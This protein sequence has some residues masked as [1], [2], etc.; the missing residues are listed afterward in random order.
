MPVR[1][2]VISIDVFIIG[3]DKRSVSFIRLSF[4]N[5]IKQISSMFIH[6]VSGLTF[7]HQCQGHRIRS[8][9][10]SWQSPIGRKL[11]DG[12]K[13][14]RRKTGRANSD[15]F[16]DITFLLLELFFNLN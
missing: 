10:E 7:H 14:R 15:I 16:L 12:L 4:E 3:F 8:G 13:T 2:T 1:N 5:R 6:N 11:R 9:N